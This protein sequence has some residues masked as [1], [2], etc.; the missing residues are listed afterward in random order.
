[1][2]F[3]IS[4]IIHYFVIILLAIAA[5]ATCFNLQQTRKEVDRP[6]DSF[7]GSVVQ[8]LFMATGGLDLDFIEDA[9]SPL[10]TSVFFLAFV[11][12]GMLIFLVILISATTEAY[13]LS[14]ARSLGAWRAEQARIIHQKACLLSSE[15]SVKSFHNPKWLHIL[16]PV[17]AIEAFQGEDINTG[18]GIAGHPGL[19]GGRG[20]GAADLAKALALADCECEQPLDINGA[21]AKF[22]SKEVDE[23]QDMLSELNNRI[24]ANKCVDMDVLAD[25]VAE[26]LLASHQK[27]SPAARPLRVPDDPPPVEYSSAPPHALDHEPEV[28]ASSDDEDMAD[29]KAVP[30]TPAP[31]QEAK[32]METPQPQRPQALDTPTKP[33]G[34]SSIRIRSIKSSKKKFSQR[35]S[36]H[37]D[38]SDD[39]NDAIGASYQKK[40]AAEE[41]RTSL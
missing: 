31:V 14:Y 23:I 40:L 17:G 18:S 4:S 38:N 1:V 35:I 26:K 16:A 5:F 20:R 12:F 32:K 27:F 34:H 7:Y 39:E 19:F 2:L 3:T 30:P 21:T 36:A 37:C 41:A 6:V 29:T 9:D 28:A 13:S 8:T 33:S 25:K 24:V 22:I 15:E 10:F 11:L